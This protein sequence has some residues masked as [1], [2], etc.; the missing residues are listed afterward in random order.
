LLSPLI[1]QRTVSLP[2]ALVLFSTL[3]LAALSGPLGVILASPLTAACIVAVK[4]LY[5][6]DV[7]EQ[8]KK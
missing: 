4:L 6:E 1:E 3:L 7:V 2:P 8:P 5:V